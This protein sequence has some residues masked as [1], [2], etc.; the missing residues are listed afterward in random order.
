MAAEEEALS[1]SLSLQTTRVE[2]SKRMCLRFEPL[3]AASTFSLLQFKIPLPF[4]G[5]YWASSNINYIY[6]PNKDPINLFTEADE[7]KQSIDS[8]A[9]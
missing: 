1:L 4:E 5:L 7:N 6:K 3:I 8:N 2:E 9:R